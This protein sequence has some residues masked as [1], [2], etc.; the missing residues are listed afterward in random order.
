MYTPKCDSAAFFVEGL[1]CER[2]CSFQRS[3]N[4]STLATREG[5]YFLSQV[6]PYQ[7]TDLEKLYVFLRHLG[8]KLPRRKGGPSYQFDDDVRL[9]HYRLQKISE[10]WSISLREGKA[11]PLDG[12]SEVGSGLVREERAALSQLIYLL[13]ERFGTQFNEADQL[14]FDQIVEAAIA[15]DGLKQAAAVNPAD[16]FE[17]VFKNLL[18]A[19]FIER[20]DQNED[21]FVRFMN[22][23]TFQKLVTAWLS[24][25]AYNK[26]RRKA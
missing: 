1:R 26:L 16:K 24:T 20:M 9:E 5:R 22:D 6:I 21:I 25:E 3:A 7:D 8:S 14:F 19:L 11:S 13:N 15:D 2:T 4:S 18:E 12:P 10:G 17:L 23:P